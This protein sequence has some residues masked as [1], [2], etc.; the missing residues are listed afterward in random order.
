MKT[1]VLWRSHGW[2]RRVLL[3]GFGAGAAMLLFGAIAWACTQRVGTLLVC[4]PPAKKFV[5]SSQ[6]G[7]V[8]G[9]TQ[10]GSPSVT[11]GSGSQLFSAK[12][13]S[14]QS[15]VYTVNFLKPGASGTDCHRTTGG[16]TKLTSTTGKSSFNGPGFYAEFDKSQLGALSLGQAKICA[17]DPQVIV[18]QV[19]VLS[20]V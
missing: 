15:T 2:R 4:R 12:A 11:S 10:K 3:T 17:Q 1:S 6:C 9:T 19:I 13:S 20:V 18:G 7:K 5:S 14:F 16:A 8:T